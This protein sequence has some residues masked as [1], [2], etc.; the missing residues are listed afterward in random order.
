M[1]PRPHPSL[2]PCFSFLPSIPSF[3]PPS[4]YRLLITY[5]FL[6][7]SSHYSSSIFPFFSSTHSSSPLLCQSSLTF[8]HPPSS[9]ILQSLFQLSFFISLSSLTPNSSSHPPPLPPLPS[10]LSPLHSLFV[11]TGAD[12]NF[13]PEFHQL[14]RPNCFFSLPPPC[15]PA[16]F[17]ACL[18]A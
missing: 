3:A 14:F 5:L 8:L 13:I 11:S 4:I 7:P 17:P 15:L 10:P 1:C 18:S 2:L 6:H 12:P 16:C 9:L